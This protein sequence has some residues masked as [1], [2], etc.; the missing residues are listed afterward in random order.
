MAMAARRTAVVKEILSTTPLK[1]TLTRCGETGSS[2]VVRSDDDVFN[3]RE[4]RPVHS[5]ELLS[6]AAGLDVGHAVGPGVVVEFFKNDGVDV[7]RHGERC[8]AVEKFVA[9]PTGKRR[10]GAVH[11]QFHGPEQ[12]SAPDR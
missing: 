12:G 2:A 10:P 1:A 7:Q 8:A 11:H 4:F 9:E 6:G 5:A 3:D